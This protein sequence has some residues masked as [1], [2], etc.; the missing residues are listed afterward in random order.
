[1]IFKLLLSWSGRLAAAFV[2]AGLFYLALGLLS[3]IETFHVVGPPRNFFER[4]IMERDILRQE[5]KI[6][7]LNYYI[8]SFKPIAEKLKTGRMSPSDLQPYCDY[9][10]RV[11]DVFPDSWAGNFMYGV[12]R[13]QEG[14]RVE[15]GAL[16]LRALQEN[17]RYIWIYFNLGVMALE[18]KD[19]VQAAQRFRQALEASPEA[20]LDS[21]L[22]EKVFWD[23]IRE[24][25]P[26]KNF[27]IQRHLDAVEMT[28][29]L[30]SLA[31]RCAQEYQ[32][33]RYPEFC[34][35]I[36]IHLQIM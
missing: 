12:C 16:F 29:V 13:A 10:Q 23:I 21:M 14:Q 9:Y 28:R 27:F 4:K 11:Q 22:R 17:P 36:E 34:S 35:G 30:L 25:A 32:G 5:V 18:D 26:D 2:L 7:A 20:S 15:A 1:M 33:G 3:R 6:K 31:E 24:I 8:P 19:F